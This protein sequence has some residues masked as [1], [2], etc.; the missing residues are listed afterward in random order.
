VESKQVGSVSNRNSLYATEVY[1]KQA[2]LPKKAICQSYVDD[3]SMNRIDIQM[4]PSL[5]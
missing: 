4:T 3:D 1:E 2:G 5:S